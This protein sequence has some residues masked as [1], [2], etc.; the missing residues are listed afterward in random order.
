MHSKSLQSCL[1]LWDPINCSPPGS[2]VHEI[3]Q[4]RILEWVAIPSSR[5]PSPPRNQ[6]AGLLCLLHWQ[7]G[8]SPLAPPGKPSEFLDLLSCCFGGYPSLF[9]LMF[10]LKVDPSYYNTF[11]PLF[12]PPLSFSV[13]PPLMWIASVQH[14]FLPFSMLV[15]W[16]C[17]GER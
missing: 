7:V 5:G 11:S 6:T 8:S 16:T 15:S 2:S 10:L 4:A 9:F 17:T 12:P 1:T 14:L 13:S 3:L